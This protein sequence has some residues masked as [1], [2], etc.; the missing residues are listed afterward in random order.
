VGEVLRFP[1]VAVPERGRVSV[2]GRTPRSSSGRVTIQLR[3]GSKWRAIA[4]ISA[5]RHGLFRLR[6]A[7]RRGAL[8][9]AR[10]DGQA[11]HPF[12]AVPTPDVIVKAFGGAP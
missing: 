12:K 10:A 5:N 1:F 9:R 11:S 6:L 3:Q 8:L 7:G 4:K 2:W